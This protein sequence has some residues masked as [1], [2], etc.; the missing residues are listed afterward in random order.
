[1][2]LYGFIGLVKKLSDSNSLTGN[3]HAI[4]VANKE[5]MAMEVYA[6]S[7]H[8]Y[9]SRSSA[10]MHLVCWDQNVIKESRKELQDN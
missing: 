10:C 7:N 3:F 6:R 1:M 4:R 5:F 8:F 2:L 9:R